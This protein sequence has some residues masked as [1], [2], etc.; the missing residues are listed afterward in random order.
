[1][2]LRS[3]SKNALHFFFF[4][5]LFFAFSLTVFSQ[6]KGLLYKTAAGSG[7]AVLDPNIDGFTSASSAGY[8]SDD[9]VESELAYTP[10]PSVGAIEPDSDLVP[11][12]SCGF[13]DL[14]KSADNNT[15]Y[16]YFDGSN[17]LM[18]RFSIGGT[19]NNLKSVFTFIG[20][21]N[22]LKLKREKIDLHNC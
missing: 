3:T 18:F 9:E 12:P 2:K 10:L 15:I 8:W 20:S 7:Q 17:N 21:Q 22:S 4:T 13:T 16:T 14:V 11:G 5:L 6:T 19:A 1:M